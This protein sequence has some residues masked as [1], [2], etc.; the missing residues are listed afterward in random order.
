[1]WWVLEVG[2]SLAAEPYLMRA[3]MCV[4]RPLALSTRLSVL[5]DSDEDR[6]RLERE[7]RLNRSHPTF[8]DEVVSAAVKCNSVVAILWWCGCGGGGGGGGVSSSHFFVVCF[9]GCCSGFAAAIWV[10]EWAAAHP[11]V[12][13]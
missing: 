10:W 1:M 3:C 6:Q 11:Q 4:C 8:R 13:P 5:L 9:A 2:L 12:T 7:V